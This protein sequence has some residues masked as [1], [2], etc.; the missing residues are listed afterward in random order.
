MG[1][2]LSSKDGSDLINQSLWWPWNK[3]PWSAHLSNVMS[4][5]MSEKP[6]AYFKVEAIFTKESGTHRY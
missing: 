2:L 6:L 1:V 4:S 3:A 5:S